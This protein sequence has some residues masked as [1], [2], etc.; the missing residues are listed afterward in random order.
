LKAHRA[1][2]TVRGL[3]LVF[4]K[5]PVGANRR[6]SHFWTRWRA[7][8]GEDGRREGPGE[9]RAVVVEAETISTVVGLHDI[10]VFYSWPVCSG[11]VHGNSGKR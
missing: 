5:D 8:H 11:P 7:L 6:P 2:R 1:L 10:S 4:A 9:A 3:S